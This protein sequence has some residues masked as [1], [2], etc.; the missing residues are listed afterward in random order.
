MKSAA[1]ILLLGLMVGFLFTTMLTGFVLDIVL[2]ALAIG[3]IVL[4]AKV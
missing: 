1:R 4:L 2:V 3:C